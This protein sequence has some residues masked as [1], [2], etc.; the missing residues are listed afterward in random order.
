MEHLAIDLV[1]EN[2]K[3]ACAT[4]TGRLSRS[5]AAGPRR[6]QCIWPPAPGAASSS[7][8]TARGLGAADAA[9]SAGHEVRVVPSTLARSLGVGRRRAEDRP[10]RCA[11]AQRGRAA[12]IC[13]RC[14]CPVARRDSARRCAGCGKPWSAPGRSCS[15]PCAAGWGPRDDDHG[16]DVRTFSARVRAFTAESRWRTVELPIE[17]GVKLSAKSCNLEYAERAFLS[18]SSFGPRHGDRFKPSPE[19]V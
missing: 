4:A 12:S 14:T 1:E 7:R 11:S 10:S 8:P 3:F 19:P 17:Q 6:C 5:G 13:P 16:G 2:P 18:P 9:L 15:T